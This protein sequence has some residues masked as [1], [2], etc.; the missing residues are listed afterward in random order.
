MTD[1]TISAGYWGSLITQ[2]RTT[3]NMS[4]EAFAAALFTNQATV[5]RWEKGHVV[6]TY[7]K[8]KKIENLAMESG[9][10]SLGGLVEVIRNSPHR[11][12]LVDE[13]NFIIASSKSSE[14]IDNQ[15]VIDQLSEKA[16]AN[17]HEMS[18]IIDTSG[19]WK[20][21]GGY[22]LDNEFDDG[23]KIWKSVII[24]VVVRGSVYAVV[25]QNIAH[26]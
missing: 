6:P 3:L 9:V 2:I 18:K 22:R 23:D 12:L 26:K 10:A 19:F 1:A 5:S 7:E 21:G 11:M 20:R 25:Q 13:H 14:W 8:Q 24:S 15:N 4:Q 17:Y 16:V